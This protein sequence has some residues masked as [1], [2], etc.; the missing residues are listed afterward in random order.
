MGGIDMTEDNEKFTLKCECEE[1]PLARLSDFIEVYGDL[2]LPDEIHEALL[3]YAKA[4][5][6][7]KD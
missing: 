3:T 4:V 6:G 1:H 2:L 5:N 7:I